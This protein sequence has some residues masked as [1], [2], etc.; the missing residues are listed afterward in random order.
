MEIYDDG[1]TNEH[2]VKLAFEGLKKVAAGRNEE[3]KEAVREVL[4]KLWEHGGEAGVVEV[5]AWWSG[6][7]MTVGRVLTLAGTLVVGLPA[8][9]GQSPEELARRVASGGAVDWGCEKPGDCTTTTIRVA[10]PP[11]TIA[12]VDAKGR[13]AVLVRFLGDER[14]GWRLGGSVRLNSR[15]RYWTTQLGQRTYLR[16]TSVRDTGSDIS[17]EYEQWFDLSRDD[18]EPAFEFVTRGRAQRLFGISRYVDA[19]ASGSIVEGVEL[20][21]VRA[22]VHFYLGSAIE[23]GRGAYALRYERGGEVGKF[24]LTAG[25]EFEKLT[26]LENWPTNEQLLT[27]SLSGLKQVASNGSDADRELLRRMLA[28][29]RDTAEKRVLLDLLAKRRGL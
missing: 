16:A 18:F 4:N 28:E 13:G 2:L 24:H 25:R 22:S 27:H 9:S 7:A 10:E 14:R 26:D 19:F 3:D 20:I 11:Q 6:E 15:Y 21:E 17:S 23:V 29:C 1:P 5:V 12:V 8:W